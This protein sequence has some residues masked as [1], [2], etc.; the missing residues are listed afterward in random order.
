VIE[1]LHAAGYEDARAAH[2]P[3]MQFID[4]DGTRITELAERTQLTKAT[5]VYLVNDLE[6]LGYVERVPDPADRRAKLVRPTARGK[7]M[8]ES[9][10]AGISELTTEWAKLIG[11]RDMAELRRLLVRLNEALWPA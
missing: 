6:A 4:D 11:E 5:V 1:R 9:A 10:R 2:A 8:V 3:V 7:R